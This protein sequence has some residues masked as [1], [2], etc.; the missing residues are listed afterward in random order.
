ME[1]RTI[2]ILD[3]PLPNASWAESS[4]FFLP[5]AGIDWI[6]CQQ[7]LGKLSK[8]SQETHCGIE[9]Q[10]LSLDAVSSFQKIYV[11]DCFVKIAP[12]AF[13]FPK[14]LEMFHY[15][16]CFWPRIG[17]FYESLLPR[18]VRLSVYL[19]DPDQC[20]RTPWQLQR[21][22]WS[23]DS[24][25]H[26]QA[27]WFSWVNDVENS[28]DE[29]NHANQC[30]SRFKAVKEQWICLVQIRAWRRTYLFIFMCLVDLDALTRLH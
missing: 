20:L 29:N 3:I 25:A 7:R 19:F 28:R 17:W 30:K 11:L 12:Q 6:N 13:V 23:C 2:P 26:P 10:V 4:T 16:K 14:Q 15:Q 21:G 5:K 18:A 24:W 9:L 8:K 1:L 22:G 27:T